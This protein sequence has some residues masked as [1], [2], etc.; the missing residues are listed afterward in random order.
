MPL[1]SPVPRRTA[2]SLVGVVLCLS[3]AC[4]GSA[5]IRGAY[6]RLGD[7]D[8]GATAGA[9]G[10]DPTVDSFADGLDLRRTGSPHYAGDVP[11][12]GPADNR[13]SMSFANIGL[14]GPAFP[15]EY[16]RGEPLPVV[17][18]GIALET[19]VRAGPTNLDLPVG[20][21]RE[22]LIAYNGDPASNG[23]GFFLNGDNYVLRLGAPDAPVG[24]PAG[25]GNDRVLGPVDVGKWHHLAYVYSLG[26]SGYYYD[27]RLVS[28]STSDPAPLAATT[29]FFLGGQAAGDA[30]RYGF[31]GWVDEVRFQSFNPI[32]AGAFEPTAFLIV[33]EPA[34]AGML[35]PMLAVVL[36]RRRR[37]N[38]API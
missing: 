19:W 27:G 7:A 12:R 5:F 35:V 2:A 9:V 26:T 10:N 29:G 4:L 8:A 24:G 33:P 36:L 21:G 18:Q 28:Q 14:G 1:P 37:G 31:N 25:T 22:E 20:P 3:P 13:L 23:F 11:P 17:V 30:I 6:Y 15:A 34:A 16:G 32:A 38:V